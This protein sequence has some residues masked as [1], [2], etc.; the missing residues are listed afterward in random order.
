MQ[1]TQG[2]GTHQILWHQLLV[3]LF[4]IYGCTTTISLQTEPSFLS[5]FLQMCIAGG[6]G[7]PGSTP[8][9]TRTR[10]CFV[11][12]QNG[13]P[14]TAGVYCVQYGKRVAIIYYLKFI[15]VKDHLRQFWAL[16]HVKVYDDIHGG[17]TIS[18][19]FCCPTYLSLGDSFKTIKLW[20]FTG[21]HQQKLS[22]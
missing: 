19:T 21:E 11:S 15:E 5:V 7:I 20:I 16:V 1:P 10:N 22:A 4:Q 2:A 17:Y 13:L 8:Q 12:S 14:V 3:L 18:W 9:R 6:L